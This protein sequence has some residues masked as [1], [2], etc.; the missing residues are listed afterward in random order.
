MLTRLDA[1]GVVGLQSAAALISS[2]DRVICIGVDEETLMVCN[3]A[4]LQIRRVIEIE[5]DAFGLT[6]RYNST[7]SLVGPINNICSDLAISVETKLTIRNRKEK[8]GEILESFTKDYES[9]EEELRALEAHD[10][11]SYMAHGHPHAINP[12]DSDPF[13]PP[14]LRR[15]SSIPQ[16]KQFQEKSEKLWNQFHNADW[17]RIAQSKSSIKYQTDLSVSRDGFCHPA[18]VL[19]A[20]SRARTNPETAQIMKDAAICVDVGDITLWASLCLTLQDGS[21]TL[22]SE[23]LGTMGYSLCAGVA[24]IMCRPN[25]AAA[26]VLAGDG[27]IQMTLQELATFQQ[28]RREGDRLIVFVSDNSILGRVAFGFDN[29][30]GCEFESPDYVALAK[31]YGGDGIRLEDTAKAAEVVQLAFQAEGLF[32]VHVLVDSHVKADM[33]NF[34][35]NSMKSIMNSG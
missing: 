12:S 31:A 15:F 26:I 30:R 18:A 20:I 29:A 22:Y 19:G 9:Q 16:V 6:T 17:I 7:F 3:V 34:T 23:R 14:S 28:H 33:A 2:C 4:G 10:K 21:R 24:S 25:P 27:G 35:D 13:L 1:K 32:I 5:P 8:V 11:F